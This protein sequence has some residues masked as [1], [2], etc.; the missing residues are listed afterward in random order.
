[1]PEKDVSVRTIEYVPNPVVPVRV[2]GGAIRNDEQRAVWTKRSNG[3]QPKMREKEGVF[4]VDL[5]MSTAR[6]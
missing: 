4:T 1:M 2:S 5:S 6:H 3:M